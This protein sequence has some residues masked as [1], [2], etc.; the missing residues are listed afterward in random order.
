MRLAFCGFLGLALGVVMLPVAAQLPASRLLWVFPSG[1]RV[2]STNEIQVG[3]TDLEDSEGLFFSDPRIL[4]HLIPGTTDRF[5]V[6]VPTEVSEGRVDLR[7]VGRFGI[8]N[9]RGFAVGRAPEVIMSS[10]NTTLETAFNLPLGTTVNG[11]SK[12]SAFSWFRLSANAGQSLWIRIDAAGLDSQLG[13]DLAVLTPEGRELAVTRRRSW[14]EFKAVETGPLYL[15]LSDSQFRGGNEYGFRLSVETSAR[16]DFVQPDILQPAVTNQ[17]IVY[18]RNLPGGTLSALKTPEGVPL[19]QLTVTL[20]P[21]ESLKSIG[22]EWIGRTA[23]LGLAE[24]GRTW[25]WTPSEA[26]RI[27]LPL[28]L[29]TRAVVTLSPNGLTAIKPPVD[30]VGFFPRRGENVGV[31]FQATKGEV[32]RIELVSE[33]LGFPSDPSGTVQREKPPEKAGEMAS[34]EDVAELGDIDGNPGDREFPLSTRD[35]SVRFEASQEGAYRVVVHDLFNLSK[36]Q[37]RWPFRLSLRRETPDFSLVAFAAPL[38]RVGEDRSVPVLPLVIRPEQTVMMKVVVNRVDGFKGAIDLKVDGLP[39]G[40]KAM[41]IRIPEDASTGTVFLTATAGA[42]GLGH[43]SLTGTA[44]GGGSNRIRAARFASV[45]WPVTDFNID[46]PKSRI[47]RDAI[48]SVVRAEPVPV[49]ISVG[50]GRPLEVAADGRITLPLRV[51]RRDEFQTAFNLQPSGASGL[52]KAKV[53]TIPEK[54]VT[55]SLDLSVADTKLGPGTHTL[56]LQ[57][58]VAGKY[59]NNVAALTAAETAFKAAEKAVGAASAADKPKA[60]EQRKAAEKVRKAAEEKA[61]PRDLSFQVF[62]EPFV[63]TVLAPAKPEGGK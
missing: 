1:A 35:A 27:R 36:G 10:T 40:V 28:T 45:I 54:A 13:A 4:A 39:M 38:P 17:V 56:W 20:G 52:A 14:I 12:A 5:Q 6:I 49:S 23:A 51:T 33:R 44:A 43:V 46:S 21:T 53:I 37:P 47:T 34:T 24:S 61:K 57:G 2:N 15:R 8:S 58:S 48:L 26:D 41:P 25:I 7:F 42:T 3:G 50:E 29:G 19:E 60:E 11:Q 9:P 62:S 55:A 63:V 30:T 59:R 16:V 32:L 22:D 18:G 31:T